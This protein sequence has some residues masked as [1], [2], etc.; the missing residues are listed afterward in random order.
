ML[1]SKCPDKLHLSDL[2]LLN[3][4]CFWFWKSVYIE[5]TPHIQFRLTEHNVQ[6]RAPWETDLAWVSLWP[7]VLA[8]LRSKIDA[9]CSFQLFQIWVPQDLYF[10]SS[11][12]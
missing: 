3:I 9:F 10:L 7:T 12:F 5:L 2:D 11:F 8:G 4:F 6:Q 1:W